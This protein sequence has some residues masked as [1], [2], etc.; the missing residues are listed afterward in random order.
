MEFPGVRWGSGS[1]VQESNKQGLGIEIPE[2]KTWS[3]KV[4][5]Q[6]WTNPHME[7][8][9]GEERGQTPGNTHLLGWPDGGVHRG[10]GG[11][12]AREVVVP[13]GRG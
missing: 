10:D 7:C 12:A 6:E 5:W 9:S 4:K 13:S 2:S 8:V 1:E 3:S 11:A